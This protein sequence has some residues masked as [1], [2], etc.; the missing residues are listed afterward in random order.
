MEEKRGR[1]VT[2]RPLPWSESD[3]MFDRMSGARTGGSRCLEGTGLAL[4]ASQN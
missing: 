2:M 1:W 3:A 4:L